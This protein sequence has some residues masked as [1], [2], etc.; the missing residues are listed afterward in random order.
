M[1]AAVVKARRA[2]VEAAWRR[3]V[4]KAVQREAA[5]LLADDERRALERGRTA[6]KVRSG[7]GTARSEGGKRRRQRWRWVEQ[8][9]S[10]RRRLVVVEKWSAA[11]EAR[12]RSSARLEE[13]ARLEVVEAAGEEAQA[14]WQWLVAVKVAGGDGGDNED[15]DEDDDDQ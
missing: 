2:F 6:Y 12:R 3:L 1:A 5:A 9:E 10:W 7:L 14:Y 15:E 11:A 8:D 13:E 4:A